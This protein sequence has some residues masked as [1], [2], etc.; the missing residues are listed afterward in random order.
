MP[1]RRVEDDSAPLTTKKQRLDAA[2]TQ[3]KKDAREV[4]ANFGRHGRGM[5]VSIPNHPIAVE[6][7]DNKDDDDARHHTVHMAI[8]VARDDFDTPVDAICAHQANPALLN[9]LHFPVSLHLLSLVLTTCVMAVC[10]VLALAHEAT[11][12]A[13]PLSSTLTVAV[14]ALA[15]CFGNLLLGADATAPQHILLG[16]TSRVPMDQAAVYVDSSFTKSI[17]GNP[18]KLVNLR[19]QN[20]EYYVKGITGQV[21]VTEMGDFLLAMS[22]EDGKTHI[23]VTCHARSQHEPASYLRPAEGRRILLHHCAQQGRHA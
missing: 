20:C 23:I 10:A 9:R 13:T 17:F 4:K 12:T 22:A 3:P 7:T 11:V 21:R 1:S 2:A 8:C 16:V 6:S 19:P 5:T 18:F 14:L 15:A